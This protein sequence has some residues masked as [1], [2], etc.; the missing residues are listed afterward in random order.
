MKKLLKNTFYGSLILGATA[1]GAFG[2]AF[3]SERAEAANGIESQKHVLI[4]SIGYMGGKPAW[5][6]FAAFRKGYEDPNTVFMTFNDSQGC[7]NAKQAL[8]STYRDEMFNGVCIVMPKSGAI[9]A[10]RT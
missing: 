4:A 6:G 5:W 1:L 9:I 2:T 8:Q 7:E 10:E 3:Y